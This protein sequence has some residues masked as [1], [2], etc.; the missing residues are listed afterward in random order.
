MNDCK[1]GRATTRP[2][3]AAAGVST[4]PLNFFDVAVAAAVL[5]RRHYGQLF[6]KRR[7]RSRNEKQFGIGREG[8][9]SSLCNGRKEGRIVR[10]LAPPSWIAAKLRKS[11]RSLISD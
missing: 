4:I 8:G 6:R 1:R 2:A 5:I 9:G 7:R 10:V 3:D 11:A